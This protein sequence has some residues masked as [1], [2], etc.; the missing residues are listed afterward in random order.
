M[1]PR[2]QITGSSSFSQEET[3]TQV[4][5]PSIRQL[6]MER[7]HSEKGALGGRM[8]GDEHEQLPP[9]RMNITLSRLGGSL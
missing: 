6:F 3:P 2:T 8:F 7:G 5:I 4:S 9:R 1:P